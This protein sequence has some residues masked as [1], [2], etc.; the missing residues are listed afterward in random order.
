MDAA[1]VAPAWELTRRGVTSRRSAVRGVQERLAACHYAMA[2]PR[3]GTLVPACVQHGVLDPAENAELAVLLPMPR[4]ERPGERRASPADAGTC[5]SSAAAAQAWSAARTA[6]SFGASVLLVERDRPGGD[7]LWTRL[8]PQQGA[9]R[10]R[11]GGRSRTGRRAVRGARRPGAGRVRDGHG[12]RAGRDRDDRA[13]RLAGRD[14]RAPGPGYAGR[15]RAVHRAG[16][17]R[18][19]RRRRCGSG[20]RWSP[21][22]PTPASA[23]PRARRRGRHR[24]DQRHRVG[25]DRAARPAGRAGRAA[26]SAAS[27]GRRSPASGRGSPS[28]RPPIGCCPAR[29]RTRP[30]GHRRRWSRDGV[31][32]AAPEP[33]H[34]VASAG[35][36]GV[37]LER[38]AAGGRRRGAG[39]AGPPP[40]HRGA[41]SGR[42]P[43]SSSPG[44][45]GSWPSTRTCGPPTRRCARRAT[46]PGTR[47]SPTSPACTGRTAAANAVLG[48]RRPV[49]LVVPRVTFTAP[50]V[51]AVGRGDRAHRAHRRPRRGRPGGR[52]GRHRPG[53]PGWCSTGAA[54]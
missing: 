18:R 17:R 42:R 54:G 12:A 21:P 4:V 43:A 45:A 19:R 51:A 27:W 33:G 53:S 38:R 7:C 14:A 3:D 50:E 28:S 29:T 41:R 40:R 11:R 23:D 47:G 9:A 13:G 20:R 16:H 52:R 1:D 35:R 48:L 49:D 24:A 39:R 34:R 44:P 36:R 8:R 10:R 32:G 15:D 5:W 30:A 22:A 6:A 26:R 37:V 2:P 46:S 25:P 31:D